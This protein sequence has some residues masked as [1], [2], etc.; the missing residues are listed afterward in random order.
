MSVLAAK[1]RKNK[2]TLSVLRE[3]GLLPVVLYGV[4][5]E[6]LSLQVDA[7][8]FKKLYQEA[9]ESSLIPLKI[10]GGEKELLVLIHDTQYHPITDEMIHA[11]LYQPNLKEETEVTVPLIFVGES[12]AV[13]NLEGTLI[14]NIQELEVKALPQNLPHEIEVSV[15]G[16]ETFEDNI[17]IK[18]LKIPEGVNISRDDEDVVVSVVAPQ[19]VDEELEKPIEEKIEEVEEE[20]GKPEEE[21]SEEEPSK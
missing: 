21:K 14:K 1:I 15:E 18:D 12:L 8:E 11:D 9:G 7:K 10:A 3:Q 16:L 19:K 17:L 6:N 5:T 20:K 2:Q 13:K 4:G